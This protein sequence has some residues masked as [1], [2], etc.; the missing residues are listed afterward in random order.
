VGGLGLPGLRRSRAAAA[1]DGGD[2]ATRRAGRTAAH[3][4]GQVLAILIVGMCFVLIVG[5]LLYTV[6]CRPRL[7][8]E[9]QIPA[10]AA[11]LAG[12]G[13]V[14]GSCSG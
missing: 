10:D 7:K 1:A 14:K 4:S 13:S 8:T 6:G 9:G 3:D 11:A 2:G 12:E 5:F